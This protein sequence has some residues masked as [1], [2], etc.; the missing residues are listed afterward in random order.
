MKTQ[1]SGVR[2][3]ANEN[4]HHKWKW[5]YGLQ[6]RRTVDTLEQNL[7][8][9]LTFHLRKCLEVIIGEKRGGQL[10]Q[11]LLEKGC[12]VIGHDVRPVKCP[13]VEL[14]LQLLTQLLNKNE[15]CL[16]IITAVSSIAP[17]VT[18]KGEHTALYNISNNVDIKA[19]TT[20]KII[21]S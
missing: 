9:W 2:S 18:D 10:P 6:S 17:Y 12:T 14:F 19:S 7:I 20:T 4:W 16:I 15:C 21:Q 8:F 3:T 5:K 1:V 13:C 11:K